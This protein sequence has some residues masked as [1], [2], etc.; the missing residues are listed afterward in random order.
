MPVLTQDYEV[1]LVFTNDSHD[2]ATVQLLRDYGRNTGAIVLLQP[3]EAVTLVLEAG[4]TYKYVI[5]TQTK[6]VS[7]S[8]HTWRDVQ[9]TVSQLFSSTVTVSQPDDITPVTVD[10]IWRDY[11]FNLWT[12]T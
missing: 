8:V 7:V 10:R 9:C 3:A 2:C 4:S 6:L 1:L 5:K 11:R 12:E